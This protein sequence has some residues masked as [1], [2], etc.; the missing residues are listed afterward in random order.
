MQLS[1]EQIL[2]AS[3]ARAWAALNDTEIL[4]QCIPGCESIAPAGENQYQLAMT[5]AIGPV[6]AR[7][8]GKMRLEDIQAPNSYTIH[9]EG[10]GGAAGHGK[11]S[12][13]VVLVAIDDS[14]TRLTYSVQAQ[15]GG[16]IA[17]VGSRLIDMAA[18]KLANDFFS[19]FGARL[20][21]E[22]APVSADAPATDDG[23]PGWWERVVAWLRR[24]WGN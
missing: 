11:G 6:K 13:Q 14:Q 16:K 20:A 1:S 9:F 17:Q 3:Q 18:Q 19:A 2:P 23:R 4:Q 24:L 7:F 5:A 8:T 22:A 21:A 15:V 12:A 10:Q